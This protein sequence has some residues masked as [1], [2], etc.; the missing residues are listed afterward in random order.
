M[1]K[2]IK[3]AVKV[4]RC[5]VSRSLTRPDQPSS[6]LVP[7]VNYLCTKNPA[8]VSPYTLTTTSPSSNPNNTDLKLRWTVR[9]RTAPGNKSCPVWG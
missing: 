4:S 1:E 5:S 2:E 8:K 9:W 3:I 7:P 6:L